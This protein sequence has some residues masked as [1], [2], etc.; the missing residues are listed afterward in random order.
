MNDYTK[1]TIA[2]AV[3]EQTATTAEMNRGVVD[4]ATARADRGHRRVAAIAKATTESVGESARR[5]TSCRDLRQ[6]RSLH[7]VQF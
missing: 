2:S 4:G 6:P 1:M 3:E 5:L 7:A